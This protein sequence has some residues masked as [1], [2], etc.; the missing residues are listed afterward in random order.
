[1]V[2]EAHLMPVLT[3]SVYKPHRKIG[4]VGGLSSWHISSRLFLIFTHVNFILLRKKI[5]GKEYI[6]GDLPWMLYFS[7]DGPQAKM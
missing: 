1:M 2:A 6:G 5:E 4:N 3:S 7:K